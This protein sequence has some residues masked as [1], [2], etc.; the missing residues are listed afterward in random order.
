MNKHVMEFHPVM[1]SLPPDVADALDRW[2]AAQ[3][4]WGD[5]RAQAINAALR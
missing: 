3:P 1:I 5:Y 4:Q 2:N